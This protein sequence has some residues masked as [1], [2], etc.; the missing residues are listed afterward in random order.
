M[1]RFLTVLGG[2]LAALLSAGTGLGV[3]YKGFINWKLDSDA[4]QRKKGLYFMLGGIFLFVIT[5]IFII[6]VVVLWNK[7]NTPDPGIKQHTAPSTSVSEN[8]TIPGNEY[9]EN[10]MFKGAR[11]TGY[12]DS[13]SRKPNGIG[14]MVYMNQN[15]Y[16]GD[17]VDGIQEGD[18]VMQY[19][20]KDSY[21]GKWKNGMRNGFGVYTWADGRKYEGNY[22]NDSRE[23]HGVFTGWIYTNPDGI[24]WEGT[25]SGE[26][27]NNH[28]EGSGKFI[29][30]SGDVFEGIFKSDKFW[31]GTY[32]RK[33]GTYYTIE[34]G[35]PIA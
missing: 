19:Y 2:V 1:L 25:Y 11:Y 26:H 33:D 5:I 17:W 32:T 22:V 18:G 29:F 7:E 16:N 30:N 10:I 20:N 12:I 3:A 4:V 34:N 23:G 24:S 6:I 13:S 35:E 14:K 27:K 9:V 28:F 8:S 15:V 31:T 21:D